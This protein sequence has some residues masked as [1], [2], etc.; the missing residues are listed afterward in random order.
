MAQKK[1]VSL[2]KLSIFLDNLKLKFAALTHTHKVSDITDVTATAT[3]L[4]RVS[5]A[6]S[7]IQTQLDTKVPTSRTINGKALTSNVTLSASDVSAYTKSEIDAYGFIT[8]AEIDTIC[9]TTIQRASSDK[10]VK[11]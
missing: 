2:S 6:T 8:T 4:N 1:Y 5:G 7:N 9:G 10:A 11:F 3:E